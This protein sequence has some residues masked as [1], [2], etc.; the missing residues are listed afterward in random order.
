MSFA[1]LSSAV[2]LGELRR[3][4]AL[5]GVFAKPVPGPRKL[6]AITASFPATV[7]KATK[8]SNKIQL[9]RS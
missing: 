6:T 5:V 1:S 2:H 9:V 8:Q 7:A 4:V 3:E